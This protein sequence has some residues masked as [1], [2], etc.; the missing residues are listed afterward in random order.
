YDNWTFTSEATIFSPHGFD[1][2]TRDALGRYSSATYGYN[3]SLPTA[4]SANAQYR[5][6][7]FENFEDYDY[8]QC[9]IKDRHFSFLKATS[10]VTSSDGE[11]FAGA[12][13]RDNV[14][15]HTGMFSMRLDNNSSFINMK[16]VI[17]PCN[18]TSN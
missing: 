15:S 12:V 3:N 5:E 17:Q 10:S 7:G 11:Y 1:L 4:L 16:K 6:I 8:E 9:S 18:K 14:E 2:E 13:S